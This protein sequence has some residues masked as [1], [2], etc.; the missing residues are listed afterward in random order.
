MKVK[1]DLV[2]DI[3]GVLS[4]NCSPS[5]WRYLSTVYDVRYEELLEFRKEIREELWKGQITEQ[6]FWLNLQRQ[7]PY[8]HIESARDQLL[9]MIIPLPAMKEI[10]SWSE[11]ADIHL[12]SNHRVEWIEH[13]INLIQVYVTSVTISAE[14]GVCKPE[15]AI[16]EKTQKYLKANG[17]V[18]FVDDQE[19][20]FIG[21]MDL[22]WD[23][24]LADKEGEWTERVSS[25]LNRSR[26]SD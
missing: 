8:L 21:A 5:F 22:G 9:S 7:I 18:L 15:I 11:V 13:I 17:I 4:T 3:A 10:P 20:N 16:Y 12:L 24:L 25:L 2:L 6:D 19:K 14:V 23:T 1:P 26:I